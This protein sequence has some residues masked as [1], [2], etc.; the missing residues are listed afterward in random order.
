MVVLI[1][2]ELHAKVGRHLQGH[3]SDYQGVVTHLSKIQ[4]YLEINTGNS[5]M[6]C[7]KYGK[8]GTG[9]TEGS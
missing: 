5:A 3:T 2:P 8:Y 9:I 4:M 6:F 1:Q 7:N